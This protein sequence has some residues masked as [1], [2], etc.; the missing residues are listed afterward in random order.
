MQTADILCFKALFKILMSP[1]WFINH[2]SNP[3]LFLA[4]ICTLLTSHLRGTLLLAGNS[5]V[6][7]NPISL[8]KNEVLCPLTWKNVLIPCH[9]DLVDLWRE[10][11]PFGRSYTYYSHPQ[12]SHSRIDHMF[13]LRK[14]LPLVCSA[15][16]LAAPWLDHDPVLVVCHS[17]L[18][19]LQYSSWV[20]NDS[21]LSL[22]DIQADLLKTSVEYFCLN[23]ASVSSPLTFWEANKAVLRGQIIQLAMKCKRERQQCRLES[24]SELLSISFKQSPTPA[25]RT[26][27]EQAHTE[28]HLCLINNMERTLRWS[29]QNWYAKAK[30]KQMQCWPTGCILLTLNSLLSLCVSV[31]MFSLATQFGCWTNSTIDSPHYIRPIISLVVK[32]QKL[33]YKA[34]YWPYFLL[35]IRPLWIVI[36][37]NQRFYNVLRNGKSAKGLVRMA[38]WNSIIESWPTS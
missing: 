24:Q 21:L 10:F 12:H 4:H 33:S 29:R 27:L 31:T 17:L 34:S 1:L 2:N 38:S 9:L 14:H 5:N 15:S 8:R 35:N 6:V 32:I 26:L 28:L 20:M 23:C 7:L 22:K 18:C 30:K 36:F 11:H 16:I 3:G 37:R 19:K 13:I 25:N